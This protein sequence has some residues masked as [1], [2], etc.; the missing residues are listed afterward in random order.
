MDQERLLDHP[1][2]TAVGPKIDTFKNNVGGTFNMYAVYV[3]NQKHSITVL[4]QHE[5]Q[6]TVGADKI[7]N[8]AAYVENSATTVRWL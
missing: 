8:N 1:Q 7:W 6:S 2:I 3:E 4:F 5:Y